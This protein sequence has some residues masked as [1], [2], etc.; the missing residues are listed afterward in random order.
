ML[1]HFVFFAM[2]IGG[3]M[4]LVMNAQGLRECADALTREGI[5]TPGSDQTPS[6]K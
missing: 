3:Y 4:Y 2:N 5:L 1:L 6:E